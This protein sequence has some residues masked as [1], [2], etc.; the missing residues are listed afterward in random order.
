MSRHSD[1]TDNKVAEAKR[2]VT[3]YDDE[4]A[5]IIAPDHVEH[6]EDPINGLPDRDEDMG[7]HVV[8][9]PYCHPED[10]SGFI[11]GLAVFEPAGVKGWHCGACETFWP[12]AG[13]DN[14]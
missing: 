3:D 12:K 8:R 14:P 2:L 13:Q 1:W 7:D 6:V 4:V 5:E 11:T 10:K 9:C